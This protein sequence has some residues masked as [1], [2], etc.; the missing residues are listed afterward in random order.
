MWSLK[1]RLGR[2]AAVPA[3]I[4]AMYGGGSWVDNRYHHADDALQGRSDLVLVEMRLDQKIMADRLNNVQMRIW[5]MEDRYGVNM[6]KAATE[7]DAAGLAEN[8]AQKLE[9]NELE[10]QLGNIEQRI[11]QY[12]YEDNSP[13]QAERQHRDRDER[14]RSAR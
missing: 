10:R 12:E 14:S 1:D 3:M 4:G 8:K 9:K 13:R 6:N 5:R 2:A 7:D 11:Q